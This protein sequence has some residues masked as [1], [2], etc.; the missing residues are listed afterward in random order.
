M[1]VKVAV[2]SGVGVSVAVTVGSTVG[3]EVKASGGTGVVVGIAVLVAC[4]VP[5]GFGLAVTARVSVGRGVFV[6]SA[7][8]AAAIEAAVGGD[9][10][11]L[12]R[13]QSSRATATKAPS[14][15]E[16]GM[17]IAGLHMCRTDESIDCLWVCMQAWLMFR[18]KTGIWILPYSVVLFNRQTLRT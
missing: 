11:Q 4:G 9:E 18:P 17:F 12:T 1:G 14:L 5:V 6:G 13:K 8:T 2:G 7:V 15:A 10:E 16:G 3:V